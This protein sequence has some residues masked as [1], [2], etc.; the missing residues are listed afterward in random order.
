MP[1]A[2]MQV[3]PMG[4]CVNNRHMSMAMSVTSSGMAVGVFMLVVPVVM[5]VTVFVLQFLVG[6]TMFVAVPENKN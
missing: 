5:P 3:R 4:M 1:V 2:V 6:M